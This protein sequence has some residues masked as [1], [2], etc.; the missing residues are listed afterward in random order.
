[1]NTRHFLFALLLGFLAQEV[2]GQASGINPELIMYRHNSSPGVGSTPVVQGNVLGTLKWNGLTAVNAIRTGAT[3]RS[4][5]SNAVTPGVLQANMIFRT[6]GA[7]GLQ[8]R[9]MISPEGRVGIGTNLPNF[10]LHTVGNT[11]TTGN[12][13]G[14]I[15]FD[16]HEITNNAPNSYHDEAYLELKNRAV[17]TGGL[18]IPASA[19]EQGGVLSMGP[20][21]TSFDHQLFL[22]ANGIW[23]RYKAGGA[24]DWSGADWNKLLSSADISGTPNRI[25][26]FL[27]PDNPSSKLG[28]SQLFDDGTDVGIGT[29]TPD[30][31]FLLTVAGDTR[32][33]GK[34]YVNGRLGVGTA[35]PA[36]ALD[37]T[38]NAR[39]SGNA[40]IAGLTGTNSLAVTTN[41][42]VGGS[43]TTNSLSVTNGATVGTNLTVTNNATTGSL[44]VTTNAMVGANLNVTNNSTTGSL[45]V[46]TNA[47]V[48]GQAT[49]L[50]KMSVGT[51]TK[52]PTYSLSVLGG[53]VSDEVRV[54]LQPWPD[55][56]FEVNYPLQPLTEVEKYVQ[57]N[58][59]LPGVMSAQ[60]VAD[61]GLDLGQTQK[62]QMEKIEELYLHLIEMDKQMK[63]VLSKNQ[64]LQARVEQLEQR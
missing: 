5:V 62:V 49:V 4:V 51:A 44:N 55:Y 12:F 16:K 30:A 52:S 34:T 6:S 45:Q 25:A 60:E 13:Y 64:A 24:V 56:V 1:M 41:T 17:L 54:H 23:S 22:G 58:K 31:A 38:G 9:M 35:A 42:T 37:V 10:E 53:I 61:N 2:S 18:A 57:A 32:I 59:H 47:T 33:N 63:A 27:A 7:T 19:G 36:E 40:T 48:N 43:T 20:G 3:I 29:V 26:R 50:Q 46:T 8:D 15:H 14:R 39:M 21:G 11:H 28:D